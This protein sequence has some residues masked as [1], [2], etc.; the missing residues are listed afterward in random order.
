MIVA[1]PVEEYI[2]NYKIVYDKV[3]E[4]IAQHNE[5]NRKILHIFVGGL[6]KSKYVRRKLE[7]AIMS[8]DNIN[9]EFIVAEDPQVAII[10]GVPI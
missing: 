8:W 9:N 10:K 2:Q 6:A 5:Q 1:V 4:K 7:D 3:R